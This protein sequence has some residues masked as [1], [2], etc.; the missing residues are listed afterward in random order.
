MFWL[1]VYTAMRS[2][3]RVPLS[4]VLHWVRKTIFREFE[5]WGKGEQNSYFE[6]SRV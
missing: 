4:P 1:L 2:F 3:A 6:S 5:G